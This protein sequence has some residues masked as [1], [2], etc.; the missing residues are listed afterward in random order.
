MKKTLFVFVITLNVLLG[1]NFEVDKSRIIDLFENLKKIGVNE[2]EG[3]DRVAYSDFDIQARQYISKKLEQIN[4][5][6]GFEGLNLHD[7]NRESLQVYSSLM[8]TGMSSRL[9]Q[10][11]RE[12]RGLVYSIMSGNIFFEDAGIFGIIT[13]GWILMAMDKAFGSGPD[14]ILI[15][16]S[17]PIFVVFVAVIILVIFGSLIGLIP[18]NRATS[19]KPIDALREE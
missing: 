8:G 19:I 3:N 7:D 13:G 6:L 14:S 12:K 17:V 5:A 15:N 9:F 10:E 2:N 18:A 4:L 1:Q 11:I 16:A